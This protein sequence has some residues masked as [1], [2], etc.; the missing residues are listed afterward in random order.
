[1]AGRKFC[2]VPN[3]TYHVFNRGVEKRVVFSSGHDHERALLTASYYQY[4]NPPIRLSHLLDLNSK[5][6]L[7][8]YHRLEN[9]SK[10]V[11]ILAYCLM[12]NHFHFLLR[13][14]QQ[15]G[16][17]QFISKWSNSYS[18]YFNTKNKRVGPLFQG[19]FKAVHIETDEQL[20]QVTR[21]IHL[22]PLTSFLV[23][24]EDLIKYPWSSLAELTGNSTKNLASSEVIVNNFKTTE[25]YIDFLM[26]YSSYSQQLHELKNSLQDD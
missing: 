13:E 19:T 6:Q 8:V 23:Q 2:F 17:S 20:L 24:K 7:N 25:N 12:P 16:I 11:K 1:M 21:Y 5:E 18:K 4:N 22:N 9:N 26:D 15:G 3:E 10:M 14:E